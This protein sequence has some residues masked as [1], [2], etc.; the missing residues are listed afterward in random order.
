MAHDEEYIDP[1]GECAEEIKCLK[2]ALS[3]LYD[4]VGV[5]R[6]SFT[7]GHLLVINELDRYGLDLALIKARR[8]L[9]I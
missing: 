5:I 4:A 2:D 8:A 1:H 3:G 6:K 9:K 7:Q